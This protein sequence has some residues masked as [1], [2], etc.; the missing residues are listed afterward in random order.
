MAS[1]NENALKVA[2]KSFCLNSRGGNEEIKGMTERAI[3]NDRKGLHFG[4]NID[5]ILVAVRK[6]FLTLQQACELSEFLG[7][8][9]NLLQEF[10]GLKHFEPNELCYPHFLLHGI[11]NQRTL[12]HVE[13]RIRNN[14]RIIDE[15][16]TAKKDWSLGSS[17]SYSMHLPIHIRIVDGTCDDFFGI[18]YDLYL[19]G[20]YKRIAKVSVFVDPSN[21]M[22]YVAT[23]QG[24]HIRAEDVREQDNIDRLHHLTTWLAADP[25]TY[26]LNFIKKELASKDYERLYAIKPTEHLYLLEG[27]Q[28]FTARYLPALWKSGLVLDEDCY[29]YCNL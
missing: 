23:F 10:A 29:V 22:A 7:V 9:C 11:Y 25:R 24:P 17:I 19:N 14:I 4:H 18:S 13:N 15:T 27:H 20:D 2:L 21:K 28:G 6:S 5:L 12:S 1:I 8:V 26:L 3:L 16:L